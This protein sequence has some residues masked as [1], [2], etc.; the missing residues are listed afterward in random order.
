[1]YTNYVYYFLGYYQKDK[2]CNTINTDQGR[3]SNEPILDH[4]YPSPVTLTP[5]KDANHTN[6]NKQKTYAKDEDIRTMM[7]ILPIDSDNVIQQ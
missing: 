4:P 2:R 6:A 3:I 1:M 7:D 5:S